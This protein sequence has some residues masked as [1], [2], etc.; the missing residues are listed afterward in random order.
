MKTLST[1]R[2]AYMVDETYWVLATDVTNPTPDRRTRHDWTKATEW[3]RGTRFKLTLDPNML[4]RLTT[5][6]WSY[7]TISTRDPRW[8]LLAENLSQDN[9][10][11]RDLLDSRNIAEGEVLVR[12]IEEKHIDRATVEHMID[13]LYEEG[14]NG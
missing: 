6:R 9:T 12:L 3:K 10:T 4:P 2:H 1:K 11:V 7:L 8:N 13:V 5:G 14:A